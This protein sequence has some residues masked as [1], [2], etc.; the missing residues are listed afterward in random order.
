MTR[1]ESQDGSLRE[2]DAPAEATVGRCQ[3]HG[4]MWRA[5]YVGLDDRLRGKT[6]LLRG[7]EGGTRDVVAQFDDV[8][9]G[10]GYGWWLFYRHQFVRRSKGAKGWRRHVRKL[11]ARA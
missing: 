3:G 10:Y 7:I 2:V 11:K 6:T 8:S 5:K 1:L 4:P 9:T